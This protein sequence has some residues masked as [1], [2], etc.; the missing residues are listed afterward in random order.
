MGNT[1]TSETQQQLVKIHNHRQTYPELDEHIRFLH[2]I[3]GLVF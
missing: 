2:A 3:P 1:E